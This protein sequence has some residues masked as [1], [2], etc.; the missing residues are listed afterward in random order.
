M[1]I[2]FTN[3]TAEEKI[4]SSSA[5]IKKTDKLKSIVLNYEVSSVNSLKNQEDFKQYADNKIQNLFPGRRYTI[6]ES[7]VFYNSLYDLYELNMYVRFLD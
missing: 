1:S 4:S 2:F 7:S 5:T 6:A 3:L